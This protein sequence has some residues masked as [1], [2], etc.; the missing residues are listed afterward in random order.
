MFLFSLKTHETRHGLRNNAKSML[1]FRTVM[2]LNL[3]F[4]K[5]SS[6]Q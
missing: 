1:P 4:H 6:Y 2:N 3:C 5:D